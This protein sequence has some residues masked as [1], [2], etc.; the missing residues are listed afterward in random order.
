[1]DRT[2]YEQD[3]LKGVETSWERGK[4]IPKGSPNESNY[5]Q[6]DQSLSLTLQEIQ[7]SGSGGRI[8]WNSYKMLDESN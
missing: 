5:E 7:P 4:Y 6:T 2:E 8:L 3:G 1:M